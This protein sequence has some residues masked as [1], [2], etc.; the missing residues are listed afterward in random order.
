MKIQRVFVSLIH[1]YFL[2]IKP[3]KHPQMYAI[4]WFVGHLRRIPATGILPFTKELA[5]VQQM[6][7]VDDFGCSSVSMVSW[8]GPALVP[9]GTT[10]LWSA[11]RHS[12]LEKIRCTKTNAIWFDI[13]EP[14]LRS[15]LLVHCLSLCLVGLKIHLFL[16]PSFW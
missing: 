11:G 15:N 8:D 16:L 7:S 2:T 14:S 10:S 6:S 4:P 9:G 3:T 13:S 12:N 1:I 5:E